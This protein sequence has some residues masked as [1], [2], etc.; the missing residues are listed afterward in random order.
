MKRAKLLLPK[1]GLGEGLLVG[2]D[3]KLIDA[4]T[5]EELVC[6]QDITLRLPLDGLAVAQTD[7]LIS[8][9]ELVELPEFIKHDP[10]QKPPAPDICVVREGDTYVKRA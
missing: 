7:I 3:A 4:D 5:G 2:K 9:I 6:C 10:P 1:Y 8:E